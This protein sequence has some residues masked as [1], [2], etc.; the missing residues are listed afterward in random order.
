V[1][2]FQHD[3]ADITC[4]ITKYFGQTRYSATAAYTFLANMALWGYTRNILLPYM[5]SRIWREQVSMYPAPFEA[6]W[7]IVAFSALFLSMLTFLH[8]YWYAL[9]I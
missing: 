6:Y 7:P 9:F 5:V 1:I 2:A 8:Y 3:I 4:S